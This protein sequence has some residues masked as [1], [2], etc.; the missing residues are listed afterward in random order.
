MSTKIIRPRILRATNDQPLTLKNL[1]AHIPAMFAPAP[2]LSRVSATYTYIPT[3]TIVKGLLDAGFTINEASQARPRAKD[4]EPFTKHMLRLR[5]P[6]AKVP[7][8]VGDLVPEVVLVNAHDGT[9]RYYL[10]A[11]IYRLV[12]SNG[13]I[14]GD[15][16]KAY[17]IAHRGGD[18]TRNQVLE[19]S[20]KI[21]TEQFPAVIGDITRMQNTELTPKQQL[22]LATTALQLRY[23]A[24]TDMTCISLQPN[25]LLELRRPTDAGEDLWHVMNRIQENIMRG[26]QQGQ[27]FMFSRQTKSKP[28]EN[29]NG[30]LNINRGLWDAAMKLAA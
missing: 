12:C 27:S 9:A 16:Y 28:I 14:M 3:I 26:G 30:I 1:E 10:Y 25:Q 22:G 13:M 29:I 21:V 17:V 2:D 20:Y 15:H 6:G 5:Y 11:G 4:R 23:P 18:I 7:K 19:G 24:V 8:K